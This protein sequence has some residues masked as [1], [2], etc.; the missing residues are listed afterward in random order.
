MEERR[1]ASRILV[2]RS[3]GWRPL[4]RPRSRWEGNIEMDLQEVG[5][6]AMD[7]INLTQDR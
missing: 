4:G 5:W 7:W 3:E 1:D 2:G 6:G